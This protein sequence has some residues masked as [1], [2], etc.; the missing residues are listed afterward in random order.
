MNI[1]ANNL[2]AE[3]AVLGACLL[4]TKAAEVV[5]GTLEPDHFYR[6]SHGALYRTFQQMMAVGLPLDT[7][8]VNAYLEEHGVL[9]EVGGR[10]RVFELAA[11]VPATA[12][13]LH[14]ANIVRDAWVKRL[15][16]RKA[17][18]L[19]EG[20]GTM[21]GEKAVI[22]LE[23]AALTIAT[24]VDNKHDIFIDLKRALSEVE[25]R[26]DTPL[27]EG[28]GIPTPFSFLDP[29][30]GG[31]LYV[32]ASYSGDGKTVLGTQF[33]STAA[34]VGRKVG[35][36]SVEMSYEDLTN[37]WLQQ[38]TG[39]P[40]GAFR[41]GRVP[42]DRIDTA[43]EEMQVMSG[44]DVKIIDDE[45]MTSQAIRKYQRLGQFDLLIIDHLHRMRWKDRHDLEDNI[46][47]IT[48]VA[49]EF[50]VPVLLLCQLAR[51][52]DHSK[53]FPV[54]SLRQLRETAML[55]A[56]ASSVWFVY[57]ERDEHHLQTNLSKFIVA[58]NRYG[59]VGSESLWFDEVST[60]F[61]EDDWHNPESTPQPEPSKDLVDF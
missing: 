57:R 9:E 3:E 35:V 39:I 50:N 22:A 15:V 26:F 7:I 13:V 2:A 56:E 16:Q 58:K 1:P 51:A 37:R 47:A 11:I 10:A 34:M 31:R 12:N 8:T 43:R 4:S 53:P 19:L 61:T 29:L 45:A 6:A 60:A 46:R 32:L 40:Q 5:S 17:M 48:N 44:W 52:G 23:E 21:S 30:Q 28:W 38:R 49:R 27:A 14:Y 41:T 42:I 36:C 18:T 25:Q 55:E 24:R 20:L 59:R 33:G 54:P